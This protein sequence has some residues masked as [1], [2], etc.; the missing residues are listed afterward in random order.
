MTFCVL[1]SISGCETRATDGQNSSTE[2][3]EHRTTEDATATDTEWY[4][5][6]TILIKFYSSWKYLNVSSLHR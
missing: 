2:A 5:D 3:G 4:D 6:F 1:K